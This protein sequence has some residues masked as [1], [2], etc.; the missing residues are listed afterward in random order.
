MGLSAIQLVQSIGQTL[1]RL[2][3]GIVARWGPFWLRH[4]GVGVCA[5]VAG[6]DQAWILR[7]PFHSFPN[8][9]ICGCA[10]I[11]VSAHVNIHVTHWPIMI[12]SFLGNPGKHY[13]MNDS[14]TRRNTHFDTTDMG[15]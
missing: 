10:A 9:T 11:I 5:F 8:G 1:G 7:R 3:R 12:D 4:F 6:D 15:D 13:Q 14:F 2:V